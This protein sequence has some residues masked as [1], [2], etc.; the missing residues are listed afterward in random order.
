MNSF[1]RIEDLEDLVFVRFGVL[2]DFVFRE[3]FPRD[4]PAG[5]IADEA[6]EVPNQKNRHVAEILKM[7][8]L[9]DQNGV[10]DVNVR[11][12]RIEAGFDSQRLSGLLR[13]LQ[14]FEQVFFADNL[15]GAEGLVRLA[16]R[17]TVARILE[18]EDFTNRMKNQ[19]PIAM[20][21]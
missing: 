15:D 16:S 6:R 21:E 2:Q 19:Q 9:P 8:H 4:R 11:H 13:A 3:L 5:R 20:H 18:R 7:F 12:R 10:A 14:L 1:F 17:Y